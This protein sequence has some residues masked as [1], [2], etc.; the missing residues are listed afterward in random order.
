[1]QQI[2]AVDIDAETIKSA[3]YLC[4]PLFAD[5]INP[6]STPLTIRLW[7]GDVTKCDTRFKDLDAITMV[8]V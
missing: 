5:Y 2:S 3:A 4:Q 8:E 7:Q 1:M 6:P